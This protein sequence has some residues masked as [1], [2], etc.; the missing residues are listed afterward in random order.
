[1]KQAI[2]DSHIHFWD[3]DQLQY[4]WL[5]SVPALDRSF[6]PQ[7]LAA[8]AAG[9]NLEKI[10]FVECGCLPEQAVQEV[11]WVSGLA[12]SEPRI[13]GIVAAAPLEQG[14]KVFDHLQQLV[15]YPLVKGVRR[16][17]QSEDPGF[18]IRPAFVEGVQLLAEFGYSFDI[19]VTHRQLGDVLQLVEQCPQ[20]SF[21]LDHIGKPGIRDGLLS[22]WRERISALA[23]YPNV[24]CKISGL[25][26]EADLAAWTPAEL[27]PYIDHVIAQF[28]I[29]RVM[30]GGDWPV[31]LLATTYRQWVETL[32]TAITTLSVEDGAKLFYENADQFYRLQ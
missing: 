16:L 6:T 9:V 13:Q 32:E 31:S 21:A 30:Y 11:E 8:Q 23:S 3:P 12:I 25:V 28:G 24:H 14:E 15:A 29:D 19:C 2:V 26:T 1:M 20:V 17:I 4:D 18:C 27:Q 22:P 5:S 7:D 10:V